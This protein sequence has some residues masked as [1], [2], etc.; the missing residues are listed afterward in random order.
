[1]RSR[2][3]NSGM[4]AACLISLLGTSTAVYGAPNETALCMRTVITQYNDSQTASLMCHDQLEADINEGI[5]TG[6]PLSPLTI[7]SRS[8]QCDRLEM[9]KEQRKAAMA[10]CH[11]K[12][13]Q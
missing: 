10:A 13:S 1:M 5:A 11:Q 2:N 3:V 4:A 8:E 9:T 6:L 7:Q 12:P